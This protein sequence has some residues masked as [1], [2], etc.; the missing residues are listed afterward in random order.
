[1]TKRRLPPDV[2]TQFLRAWG[3]KK[4]QQHFGDQPDAAIEVDLRVERLFESR[5]YPFPMGGTF[6]I[7]AKQRRADHMIWMALKF[8][9]SDQGERV[10]QPKDTERGWMPEQEYRECVNRIEEGGVRLGVLDLSKT[11]V[12][13]AK[14]FEKTLDAMGRLGYI[15]AKG[16]TEVAP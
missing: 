6:K 5:V 13:T 10:V 14:H 1:M 11:S 3:E 9:G 16:D 8:I 15:S 7:L 2:E 12:A 4:S